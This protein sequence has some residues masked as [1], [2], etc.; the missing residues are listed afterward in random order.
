[1]QGSAFRNLRVV[2]YRGSGFWGD[3]FLISLTRS[4]PTPPDRRRRS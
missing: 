4:S 2:K 1:V 3:E